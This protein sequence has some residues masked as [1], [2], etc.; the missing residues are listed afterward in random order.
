MLTEFCSNFDEH[1]SV[2][3]A[4]GQPEPVLAA[5]R[6]RLVFEREMWCLR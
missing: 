1:G 5:C 2:E 4:W 6:R 3:P